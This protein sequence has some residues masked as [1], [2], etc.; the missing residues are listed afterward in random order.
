MNKARPLLL[1]RPGFFSAVRVGAGERT[2]AGRGREL[3][4]GGGETRSVLR[5]AMRRKA[6][7]GPQGNAERVG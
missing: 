1:E 3:L 2:A 6:A 5:G 7:G 4:R